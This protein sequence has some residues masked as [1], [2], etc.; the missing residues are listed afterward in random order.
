MRAGRALR[1]D[2]RRCALRRFDGRPPR[3]LERLRPREDRPD[4]GRHRRALR[5]P[6]RLP[7]ERAR[8]RAARTSSGPAGSRRAPTPR[9][10]R[11]WRRKA[12][13]PGKLALQYWFFYAF[14]DFNN[15]HEGDWEMIQL[16]FD[17][18]DAADALDERPVEVGYSSHEGAEKAAWDDDKLEIVG[19]THP[20]V[21]PAAGSHAN[22]FTDGAVPRQLGRG[23][24][25]LRRH[26][27]AAS[28]A[29]AGRPHDPER[30]RGRRRG[31]P[32][33]HVRGTVGRAAEGLLQRADRP[34]HEDA[35]ADADRV[36]GGLARSQLRRADRGSCSG[37][38]PPTSSAPASS[39]ARLR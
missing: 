21:Y 17:A 2:G 23:R 33:D 12:T 13:A 30:R 14:N 15:T 34:Q 10:T 5:V 35:V 20:V 36:V 31:V 27:R 28:R 26:S 22:K 7:G 8:A 18:D 37:R 32:V 6:P 4:G 38:A 3:P 39:A 24:G 16:V 19:G 29:H 9:S 25:R 1:A 11:T